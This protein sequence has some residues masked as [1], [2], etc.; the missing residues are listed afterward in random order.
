MEGE[1]NKG[2]QADNSQMSQAS[3]ESAVSQEDVRAG[4]RSLIKDLVAAEDRIL[5]AVVAPESGDGGADAQGD[6]NGDGGDEGGGGGKNDA[7]LDHMKQA[8]DLYTHVDDPTAAILDARLVAQLSRICRQQGEGLSTNAQAFH[9]VEFADKMVHNM[10]GDT[11]AK[12]GR[13]ALPGRHWAK[14]GSAIKVLFARPPG[15]AYLYG[16]LEKGEIERKEK[17]RR[18]KIKGTA[19]R[20][21]VVTK[22]KV[23]T[24]AENA[25]Q[26][27]KNRTEILIQ[28]TLTQLVSKFREDG[29]GKEPIDYLAFVLNRDSFAATVENVF[30]CSFLVKEGKA[31]ISLDDGGQPVISPTRKKK[32]GNTQSV[33]DHHA[34]KKQVVMSLTMDDWEELKRVLG[35]PDPLIDHSGVLDKHEDH[36][37]QPGRKRRKE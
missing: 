23:M 15:L 17:Q 5:A 28:S 16:S 35:D 6:E 13:V 19:D 21:L 14:L 34:E 32:G 20:D 4:Y 3:Q 7:L 22:A 11:D 31:G 8:D 29:R 10:G 25:A 24:A 12:T 27:T 1:E 36:K 37:E 18:E 2:N 30:H 33:G 26:S 9:M